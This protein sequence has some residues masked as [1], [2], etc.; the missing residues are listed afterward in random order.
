MTTITGPAESTK[1]IVIHNKDYDSKTQPD[2]SLE[3]ALQEFI[4]EVNFME[5]KQINAEES[6]QEVIN[7]I[8]IQTDQLSRAKKSS[9]VVLRRSSQD[10]MPTTVVIPKVSVLPQVKYRWQK[11]FRKAPNGRYVKVPILKLC[12]SFNEDLEILPKAIRFAHRSNEFSN[13]FTTCRLSRHEC[14]CELLLENNKSHD[15]GVEPVDGE[16]D[17]NVPNFSVFVDESNDEMQ[18]AWIVIEPQ[19]KS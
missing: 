10:P 5:A 18:D 15:I 9:C 4:E 7:P 1:H 19:I 2:L 14:L 12:L 8:E 17:S 3:V 6:I 11:G 13:A 16:L